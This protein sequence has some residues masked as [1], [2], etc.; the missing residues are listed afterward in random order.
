MATTYRCEIL[1][2][3]AGPIPSRQEVRGGDEKKRKGEREGKAL[4][5][6]FIFVSFL[7]IFVS[8]LFG[9]IAPWMLGTDTPRAY[10]HDNYV[11][12]FFKLSKKEEIKVT[13]KTIKPLQG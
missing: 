8:W 12:L 7:P 5:Y 13:L 1:C 11:L 6:L 3:K 2:D 4:A 10:C 9:G